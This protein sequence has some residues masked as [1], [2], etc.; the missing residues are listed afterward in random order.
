VTIRARGRDPAAPAP[1][2]VD[3]Y[4]RAISLNVMSKAYRLRIGF[5]RT[6]VTE[7]LRV[8]RSWLE[9]R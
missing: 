4:E 2:A 6:H 9:R 8:L 1:Q 5:G 7:G 3:I